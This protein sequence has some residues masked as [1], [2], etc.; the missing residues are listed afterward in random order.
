MT[1]LILIYDTFKN[2]LNKLK[3]NEWN[4]FKDFLPKNPIY[5][6]I[7]KTNE[8]ETLIKKLPRNGTGYDIGNAI[9]IFSDK[10]FKDVSNDDIGKFLAKKANESP[11]GLNAITNAKGKYSCWINLSLDGGS[12]E[13]SSIEKTMSEL[14]SVRSIDLGNIYWR[15]FLTIIAVVVSV[16]ALLL[17]FVTLL[18][19]VCALITFFILF[20]KYSSYIKSVLYA[21]IFPITWLIIIIGNRYP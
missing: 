10:N 15:I 21:S 18:Y 11:I 9:F 2:T 6:T 16:I 7:D 5:T 19:I 1:I 12:F 8:I 17:M 13:K 14:K 3:D 4:D 20:D